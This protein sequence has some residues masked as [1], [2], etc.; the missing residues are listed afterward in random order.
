MLLPVQAQASEVVRKDKYFSTVSAKMKAARELLPS[1][2]V[3][4]APRS[5][6]SIFNMPPRAEVHALQADARPEKVS[7]LEL[8]AGDGLL[9]ASRT[10]LLVIP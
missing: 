7:A 10:T 8:S 9:T 5:D 2:G 6:A 4:H 3:K 1:L